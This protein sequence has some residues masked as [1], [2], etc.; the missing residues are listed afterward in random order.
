MKH[1]HPSSG[2]TLIETVIA[3][4]VLGLLVVLI[5]GGSQIAMNAQNNSS[6]QV[7][8]VN[9]RAAL[10]AL[11]LRGE[12]LCQFKIGEIFPGEEDLERILANYEPQPPTRNFF[13]AAPL[14]SVIG[15][16]SG[17]V[18][19]LNLLPA[20][21]EAELRYDENTFR[22]VQSLDS[23]LFFHDYT[24]REKKLD[25]WIGSLFVT[26]RDRKSKGVIYSYE[27]LSR[28]EMER[29][30]TTESLKV[31]RCAEDVWLAI[32]PPIDRKVACETIGGK[33]DRDGEIC[34]PVK[35]KCP[36]RQLLVGVVDDKPICEEPPPIEV[37]S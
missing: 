16:N 8:L 9:F 5:T 3:M 10:N 15:K 28:L 20:G 11:I 34:Y 29:D 2:F 13:Y 37:K 35:I 6:R 25:T 23:Q 17:F 22:P 31:K 27:F 21:T 1:L 7:E 33:L 36:D 26:V 14:E 19:V 30:R 18:N 32:H 24:R 12:P 4:G